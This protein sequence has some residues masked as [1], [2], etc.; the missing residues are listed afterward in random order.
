MALAMIFCPVFPRE[1]GRVSCGARAPDSRG[2][3]TGF[4]RHTSRQRFIPGGAEPPSKMSS[5]TEYRTRRRT[6]GQLAQAA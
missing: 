5:C 6:S 4:A 1:R 3:F 2:S